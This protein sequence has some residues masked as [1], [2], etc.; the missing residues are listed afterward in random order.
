[1]TIHSLPFI[2]FFGAVFLLYYAPLRVRDKALYQNLLLLTASYLFYGLVN[3]KMIPLLIATSTVYYALGIAIADAGE[4]SAKANMLAALGACIGVALLLYFKYLNFFITSFVDLFHLFGLQVNIHTLHIIMPLGL[5]FWT[6]KLIS[7]C[8]E[9]RDK[10]VASVRGVIPFAV[11]VAFFPTMTAGPIDRPD[12]FIPQLRSER[13]FD[14]RI[15]VDGVRQMLWGMFKKLVIADRFTVT[16][17]NAW[18]APSK[19]TGINL[20]IAAFLFSV[21]IYA[22]FSGYSDMAIGAGKLLALNTTKNFN[23][24]FFA[25]NIAEFWRNWHISL[26]SWLTDYVFMPLH[27]RFRTWGK[28][29]VI[30]AISI[31]FLLVG[32]WH[33]ANWTFVVLGVYHG[34]L[35]IPL[36]I[37]ENFGRIPKH[38]LNKIGLP[39]LKDALHMLL[40]FT[41]VT[42]GMTMLRANN[43]SHW[44][45][46]LRALV[47]NFFPLV[48]SSKSLQGE[49]RILASVALLFLEWFSFRYKM[50]YA[51]CLV[52]KF[53]RVCRYAVY[54]LIAVLVSAYLF[55]ADTQEFVYQQF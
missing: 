42:F 28:M 50:E 1:M 53:N 52:I 9:V 37:S 2:V 49:T 39:P 45:E 40:T 5:S 16:I 25:R 19:T 10:T 11:Y 43:L 44:L 35:Y 51:L 46:Y 31:N 36:I 26:T 32:L 14:Y 7:Y 27:D 3:W 12:K 54:V 29:G 41:L 8:F 13:K 34:I 15:A 48:L 20:L 4:S 18:N 33:G 24:P 22:D 23:Y 47:F 38:R 55:G 6:F 30:L 17:D 21:Q